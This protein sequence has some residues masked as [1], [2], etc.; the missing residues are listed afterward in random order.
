M[1]HRFNLPKPF[2][3]IPPIKGSL[4]EICL[5]E[6]GSS[7]YDNYAIVRTITALGKIAIFLPTKT[8]FWSSQKKMEPLCLT[9]PSFALLI[10]MG[11]FLVF[12]SPLEATQR[13]AITFCTYMTEAAEKEDQVSSRSH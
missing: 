8:K 10:V 6:M 13:T 9:R 7:I 12:P 3:K 2:Q 11:S 1:S 4:D 5:I